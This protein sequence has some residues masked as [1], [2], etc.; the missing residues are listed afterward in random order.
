LAGD[1]TL[2]EDLGRKKG[3]W[4]LKLTL[5]RESGRNNA[6]GGYIT[7]SAIKKKISWGELQ[8]GWVPQFAKA[9]PSI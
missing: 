1:S 3:R 5:Q 2:H 6:N 4:G 7:P 8:F 9:R